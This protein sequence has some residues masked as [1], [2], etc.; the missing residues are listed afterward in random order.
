MS[1]VVTSFARKLTSSRQDPATQARH[2][3]DGW[4]DESDAWHDADAEPVLDGT[5]AG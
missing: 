4:F 1:N 2:R 5:S 3:R